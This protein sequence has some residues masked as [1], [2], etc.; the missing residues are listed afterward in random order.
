MN[1]LKNLRKNWII[2]WLVVAVLSLIV[3][4]SFAAYTR[5]NVVKRVISTGSGVG[6]RFSSDVMSSA[7]TV[8][9]KGFD[10]DSVIPS[11]T[12]KVFNYPYPKVSLYRNTVTDYTLT[13]TIGTYVNNA[14]TPLSG[15]DL[16][17]LDETYAIKY[18]STGALQTFKANSGT[19]TIACSM[20]AGRVDPD[21]I[22]MYFSTDELST[23]ENNPAPGYYIQLIAEPDDKELPTLTGYITVRYQKVAST[24]WN[25]Y[26]ETLD[27][28]LVYDGYNYTLEGTG[29]GRIT[30]KYDPEYVTINKYFLQ[31]LENIFYINNTN[32][33]GSDSITEDSFPTDVT[34]G[35]KSITMVVNS[36]IKN[37]YVIQ[38]Y[39]KDTSGNNDYSNSA[40]SSYLPATQEGDWIEVTN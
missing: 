1:V 37:R 18:K 13:A 39:K 11:V 20:T 34:T 30:F 24:G 29:T 25:G 17:D 40:I 28:N 5:V 8:T 16:T 36:E 12:G 2:V 23:D 4:I 10:D 38:F 3:I 14:F 15:S 9:R 21:E 32:T 19:V 27:N 6:D 31:N 33:V 22:Y 26:L 7:V 35:M